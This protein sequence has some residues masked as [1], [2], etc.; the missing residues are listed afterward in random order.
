MPHYYAND[1]PQDDGYH[2]VHKDHHAPG[3]TPEGLQQI[4]DR[5][6]QLRDLRIVPFD[7]APGE[8][9]LILHVEA[10]DEMKH[11]DIYREPL[12]I[13]QTHIFRSTEGNLEDLLLK[14]KSLLPATKEDRILENQ[15]KILETLNRIEQQGK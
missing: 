10:S 13:Q 4:H 14:I 2:E 15:Q 6:Y 11:H 9:A 7:E 8:F 5:L 1:N 3:Y 12:W